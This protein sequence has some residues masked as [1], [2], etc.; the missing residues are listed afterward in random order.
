MAG[1]AVYIAGRLALGLVPV[2]RQF[3]LD[4]AFAALFLLRGAMNLRSGVRALR[5][6]QQ[7]RPD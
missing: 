3:W 2:T 4:A 1:L 5:A 7:A 6:H